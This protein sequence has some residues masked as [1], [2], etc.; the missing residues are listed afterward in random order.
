MQSSTESISVAAGIIWNEQQDAVF[1]T[2]R[3]PEQ[4]QGDR[5]EFP[6]GKC[7]GA[8]TVFAALCRELREEIGIQVMSASP[9]ERIAHTYPDKQ[10]VLYFWDVWCFTG[11]PQAREGQ[12]MQWVAVS[13][14]QALD[15]PDANVP[16]VEKLLNRGFKPQF[17]PV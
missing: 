2:F 1:L 9:F 4:H 10:V 16:I 11:E 8:E 15:F 3:K 17:Y 7:D 5:W 6:G 13:E 14:L 12:P